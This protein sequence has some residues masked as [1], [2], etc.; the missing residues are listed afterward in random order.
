MLKDKVDSKEDIDKG[1][2]AVDLVV[3]ILNSPKK[4]PMF[5]EAALV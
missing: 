3:D 2:L 5:K 1:L 4:R